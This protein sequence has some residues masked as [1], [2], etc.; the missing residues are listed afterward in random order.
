MSETENPSPTR[1]DALARAGA[2]VKRAV[3]ITRA[4]AHYAVLRRGDGVKNGARAF[5]SLAREIGGALRGGSSAKEC[6]LCGWTGE[7]FGP[8]YYVD[9][10]REDTLC[11]AC[12][13]TDRTR[14]LPLYYRKNLA[15]FFAEGKKRVLD[16]GGLRGSR[17]F[18]PENVDYVSFDLYAPHAMVRGDLCAAPFPDASFDLWVCFHVLDLIEDDASAMR[19]LYRLLAPGGIGL[20]DNVMNWGGPTEEYG[21]ARPEEAMHRRR[22]GVDLLD[23]L[24]ALGFEVEVVD[25]EEVFDAEARAR[26]GIHARKFL[27]C[28]KPAT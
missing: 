6:S 19:E 12:G 23:R 4:M 22:Y 11:Y 25:T 1:R 2:Y 5:R 20:L 13:S 8:V 14:L 7:R 17:R 26:Y 3:S 18:F 10:Y 9:Q 28:K 21:R 15:G 24:R 27:A 16:I